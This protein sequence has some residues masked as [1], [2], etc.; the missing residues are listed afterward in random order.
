MMDY[1]KD[2][3]GYVLTDYKEAALK[4]YVMAGFVDNLDD[5]KEYVN[6][7]ALRYES[8]IDDSLDDRKHAIELEHEDEDISE[9][10][11]V[12][13]LA[14][15]D[16]L[17]GLTKAK[18]CAEEWYAA[19]NRVTDF[20]EF[21]ALTD[22]LDEDCENIDAETSSWLADMRMIKWHSA[23]ENP[24]IAAGMLGADEI[25]ALES[26]SWRISDDGVEAF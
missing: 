9:D 14:D 22:H 11:L 17:I 15:D 10:E 1:P 19:F 16:E 8:L 18:Q 20:D 24:S 12:E 5:V 3:R 6:E 13:V 23:A 25:A 2:S 4:E 26:D 7:N 21:Y